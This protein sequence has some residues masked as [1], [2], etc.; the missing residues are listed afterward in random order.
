M[1]LWPRVLDPDDTEGWEDHT[2][3]QTAQKNLYLAK[4][5]ISF[6]DARKAIA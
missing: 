6:S 3:W 1:Y 2:T 5:A 4:A